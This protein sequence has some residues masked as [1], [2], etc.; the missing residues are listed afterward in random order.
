MIDMD[1]APFSVRIQQM[2]LLE[3]FLALS[4]ANRFWF[5][6][7]AAACVAVIGWLDWLVLNVSLG[8]LYIVP[9]LLASATLRAPQMLLFA[10]VCGVLRELFSPLHHQPGAFGRILI[11]VTGFALAGFFVSELN[12]TRKLATRHLEER[13]EQMLLRRQAEEQ[14]RA[15]IDTSPLA[16]LTLD[17]GGRILLANE[18]AQQV[19]GFQEPLEGKEIY[20]YLPILT[21]F[22]TMQ[23]PSSH[24]RTAV[25]SRGQRA[26]GEVFLANIWLSTYVTGPGPELAACIWDASENLRDREGTGLNSMMATSRVLIGAVSHEIRNLATAALS[27]HHGLASVPGIDRVEHFRALGTIITGLE[28][29]AESGLKLSA[30]DRKAVAN[31]GMVLDE[32]RVVIEPAFHDAGISIDWHFAEGL[33]LVQVDHHSLLQVF[34]NLAR[35][36]EQ[37]LQYSELKTLTV[38]AGLENDLVMVRF[39]DTGPG[40]SNPDDLFKPFQPG[41]H[42]AGLGLYISRAVVRSYGGD[43]FFE[44]QSAGSCFA[45]QLWPAEEDQQGN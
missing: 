8:F 31:L 1:E 34:L 35:N 10:T 41:A 28:R 20:P 24:L 32:T 39:R 19:L 2:N 44:P 3:R 21:R 22:L 11:G 37:A 7:I 13:E 40:I 38:T 30:H 33:P 12:R 16:I 17:S 15:V 43:L 6:A 14:L 45:L 42:S 29:I 18:S 4:E 25:E 9:M 36:S 23:H 27:A 5:Y 26:D